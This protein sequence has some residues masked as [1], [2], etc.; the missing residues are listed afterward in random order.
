[1]KKKV[2][3]VCYGIVSF[4]YQCATPGFPGAYTRVTN[5]VD[6]VVE[7]SGSDITADYITQGAGAGTCADLATEIM[8]SCS[9]A[10][11]IP[12]CDPSTTTSQAST[13]TTTTTTTTTVLSQPK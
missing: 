5:Y 7:T 4:G 11:G 9:N 3:L 2:D 10:F 8:N 1:M 13:T 6:W 12:N